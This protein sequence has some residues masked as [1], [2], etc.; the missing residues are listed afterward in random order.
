MNTISER[1]KRWNVYMQ[2]GPYDG[3]FSKNI[4]TWKLRHKKDVMVWHE[5][6]NKKLRANIGDY[7]SNIVTKGKNKKGEYIVD[8]KRTFQI[9]HK[10]QTELK[11]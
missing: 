4:I 9:I 3:P 10:M 5:G 2:V 8:Y 11:L 7:V 6:P 1:Q